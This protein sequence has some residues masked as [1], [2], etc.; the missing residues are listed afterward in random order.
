MLGKKVT[1]LIDRKMG[2]VHPNH[3]DILYPLNYGYIPGLLAEDGEEQDA[4]VLGIDY[5]VD[6]F[7][8]TVIAIIHREDDVEDKWV[9]A[10]GMVSKE[11]IYEKT[12]FQ[13][14]YFQT[15]I[16]ML[17]TSYEDLRWDLKRCGLRSDDCLMIHSSLKSVGSLKDGPE[18]LIRA[19][20]D[21]VTDGLVVFP[22]HTWATIRQD[23]D[24]FDV[25]E[26]DSCVGA[27]T[28]IARRMPGFRRSLHPT[29]SVCAYGKNKEAYLALDLHATTPVPPTGCFGIL[30]DL[31]AKILF[32]GAPLS[33]NTFIHSIEEAFDVENRFTDHVYHFISREED[34][35]IDFYMPRHYSTAS[36]H[37]S[38]HYE[39]LLPYFLKLN[40][41]RS[42]RIG[43]SLSYLVDAASCADFVADLLKDDPHVFDDYRT[44]GL[45]RIYES[46]QK[47]NEQ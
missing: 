30:K 46:Y 7:T 33:K 6:S 43:N 44:D 9:V 35:T 11:E 31:K 21:A 16:E 32:L 39:K 28:N 47:T 5:P 2:S 10:D 22:T 34:R 18:S 38:D 13:E 37:I 23:G 26:S 25:L 12:R 1:V 40:I 8:G 24:V 20:C 3:P 45:E 14:Q 36:M 27:L 41:A 17:Q 19:F 4:Y 29:H 42:C 15:Y